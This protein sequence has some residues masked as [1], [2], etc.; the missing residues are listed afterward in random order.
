VDQRTVLQPVR[1]RHRAAHADVR[2]LHWHVHWQRHEHRCLLCWFVLSVLLPL[3]TRACRRGQGVVGLVGVEQLLGD[4]VRRG[5][6]DTHSVL[7]GVHR[8]L[9]RQ[10][11]RELAV[12][13]RRGAIVVGLGRL[14]HAV[15]Q[16]VWRGRGNAEPH[17]RRLPR[18]MRG[19]QRAVCGLPSRVRASM[20]GMVRVVAVHGN[21]RRRAACAR[22]GV[23]G[24]LG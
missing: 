7:R 20:V 16:S 18:H 22:A 8:L 15:Q 6:G 19:Q 5:C 21:M 10:Q 11:H 2:R 24:L 3:L 13:C 4:D 17:L 1:R 9:R 23:R 12:C 14:L